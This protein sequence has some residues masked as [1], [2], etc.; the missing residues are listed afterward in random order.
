[1]DEFAAATTGVSHVREVERSSSGVPFFNS[2]VA[3]GEAHARNRFL[4]YLNCDILLTRHLAQVLRKIPFQRFLLIGERID[5]A[6]GVQ[7]DMSGPDWQAGLKEL[8]ATGKAETHG[9]TGI[10]YFGFTKGQ[11]DALKPLVVGR[12]GYDNALL[13]YCLR[14]Q[15]PIIDATEAVLA[16]HQ[17]HG[18]QHLGKFQNRPREDPDVSWNLSTHQVSHSP[19]DIRDADLRLTSRLELVPHTGRAL[20][21]L[22]VALHYRLGLPFLWWPVRALDR[23]TGRALP[24]TPRTFPE[25]ETSV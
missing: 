2:I 5:L 15:L 14:H 20:R 18:Y 4:M 12:I 23:M 3:H 17:F 13:A 11:W 22:E 24:T 21:K 9:P 6:E 1:M 25:F 16:L 10:D 19:P 8:L 7:L